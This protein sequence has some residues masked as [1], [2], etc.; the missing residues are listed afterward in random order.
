MSPIADEELWSR[1]APRVVT[2]PWTVYKHR[3]RLQHLWTR[4]LGRAG[5]G[6]TS[7]VVVG[8]PNVGKSVFVQRLAHPGDGW[9]R[10]TPPA[11]SRDV[12]A[13][14]IP[15]GPWARLA[16]VL[17]GETSQERDRGLHEAFS[18]HSGLRGVVYVVDWGYTQARSAVVRE[19]LI[20]SGVDT[21]AKLR[22]RNLAAELRDFAQVCERVRESTSRTGRPRW[23]LVL[24]TKADLFYDRLDQAQ[25]YYDP[26]VDS[27]FT[28]V[29]RA[30]QAQVGGVRLTVR[31]APVSS[32]KEPF[33]WHH[34]TQNP[35]VVGDEQVSALFRNVV[36][37]IEEL[38][39]Q[40]ALSG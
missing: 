34:E 2:V 18:T 38:D 15:I 24:I 22:A 17:P 29:A 19:D 39:S 3:H 33:A 12:E 1:I 21:I 14:V 9:W 25:A 20:G 6:R 10:Y 31:A 4:G 35:T 16:R 32:W 23:L 28:A 30:L 26:Q 36:R 13:Q 11:A 5:L 7:V 8:R 37:T 27:P 40:R